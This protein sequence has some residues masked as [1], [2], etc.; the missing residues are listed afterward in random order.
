MKCNCGGTDRNVRITVG[1]L[2]ILAAMT[3]GIGAWGWIGIVPLL[4]AIFG[5]CPAY[6]LL[7]MNTCKTKA[8]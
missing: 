3:G 1:L 7:G 6:T 5:F 4:T 2:L 8:E